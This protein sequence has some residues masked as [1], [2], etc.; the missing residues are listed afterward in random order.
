MY[1]TGG[2]PATPTDLS[3]FDVR[4]VGTFQEQF[5][6]PANGYDDD[7]SYIHVMTLPYDVRILCRYY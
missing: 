7:A 5:L 4:V 6:P 2:G 3:A 1:K